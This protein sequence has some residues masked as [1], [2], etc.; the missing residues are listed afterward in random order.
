MSTN[1]SGNHRGGH[2]PGHIRDTFL[3]ATE[4]Y[5][6]RSP[7]EPEPTVEHEVGYVPRRISISA[8]C[9]LVWNC[10]DCLPGQVADRLLDAGL[11]MKS[12]TFAAAA[13]A[14]LD[15]LKRDTQAAA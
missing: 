12:R 7:G 4:A 8:A 11:P 1:Y 15:S 3:A 5:L 2:C 9:G 13:R 14:M 6:D 10:T